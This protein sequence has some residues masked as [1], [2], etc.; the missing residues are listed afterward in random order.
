MKCYLSINYYEHEYFNLKEKYRQKMLHSLK[1]YVREGE[2]V[3][4]GGD[5]CRTMWMYLM[6]KNCTL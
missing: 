6:P 4:D 1:V 2:K 5:S 3:L